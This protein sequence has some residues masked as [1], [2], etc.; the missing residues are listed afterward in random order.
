MIAYMLEFLDLRIK[1]DWIMQ[2]TM[3]EDQ[4]GK[5]KGS[6]LDFMGFRFHGGDV[7][8]KSY[9]GRQKKHKK[10]WVT[11]RRNIFLPHDGR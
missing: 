4:V 2:K 7:E 8:M 3:Y 11:I 9:F 10:V 1:P 6:L 5:T